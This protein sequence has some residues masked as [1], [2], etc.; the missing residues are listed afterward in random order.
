MADESV[1][2]PTVSALRAAGHQASFIAETSPGI[3][4][5][6]VLGIACVEQA[7]LLTADK[8]FGELVFRNREA[9]S[10]ILLIRSLDDAHEN[11]ANTVIAIEQYRPDLLNRFS[12]L[13]GRALRIRMAP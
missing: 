5:A 11:A 4:D 3:E 1:E 9:H 2:R 7:L 6:E 8:D 10:G 13:M 12:V